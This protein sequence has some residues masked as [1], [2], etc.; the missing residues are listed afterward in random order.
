MALLLSIVIL[1]IRPAMTFMRW[2]ADIR[3]GRTPNTSS[4]RALHAVSHAEMALVV[5]MVFVAGFMARGFGQR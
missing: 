5:L 3:R 2:R 1:E 4:A